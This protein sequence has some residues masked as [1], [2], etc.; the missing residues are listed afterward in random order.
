MRCLSLRLGS[1]ERNS[2]G[3][4]RHA[5][6]G[7]RALLIA[8]HPADVWRAEAFRGWQHRAVD[9]SESPERAP[10]QV[11]SECRDDGEAPWAVCLG[12]PA[13]DEGKYCATFRGLDLRATSWLGFVRHRVNCCSM[14]LR[15]MAHC[16][17]SQ[18]QS[19]AIRN[20]IFLA[21]SYLEH[22]L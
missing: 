16:V 1:F 17:G 19:S 21:A 7:V 8:T 5:G 2:N 18:H 6:D 3:K 12:S 11:R 13:S 15:G 22:F 10:R 14:G 4:R 9:R 20:A